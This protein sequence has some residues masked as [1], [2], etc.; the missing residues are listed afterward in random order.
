MIEK[1]DLHEEVEQLEAELAQK[2]AKL[3]QM[4]G[5]DEPQDGNTSVA[6][7]VTGDVEYEKLKKKMFKAKLLGM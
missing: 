3:R 7:P 2:K 5:V 1:K 6:D 4:Q